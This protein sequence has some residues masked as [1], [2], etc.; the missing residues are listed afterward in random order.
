M[1][2]PQQRRYVAGDVLQPVGEVVLAVVGLEVEQR[3][4]ELVLAVADLGEDGLDR[5]ALIGDLA[6]HLAQ[7][8]L[9]AADFGELVVHVGGLVAALL[10]Q[11]ALLGLAQLVVQR[12]DGLPGIALDQVLDGGSR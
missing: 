6:D 11:R 1:T 12:G 8:L 10:E 3:A 7:P 4:F 9:A 2:R 5:A